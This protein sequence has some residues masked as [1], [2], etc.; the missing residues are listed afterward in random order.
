LL[1]TTL[2]CVIDDDDSVRKA[3]VELI[4]SMGYRCSGYKS[5]EAVLSSGEADVAACIVT[6]IHMPGL[7]GFA[8]IRELDSR[9]S[10]AGVIVIT[11]RSEEHLK[12][13]ALDA[14]AICFLRKPLRA[15]AL[16]RAI[17]LSSQKT[18]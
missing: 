15:D 14:G 7:D 18:E 12:G 6:D 3:L 10:R 11:G 5:A 1:G 8:L 9:G 17:T 13:R 2:V 4:T 16:V